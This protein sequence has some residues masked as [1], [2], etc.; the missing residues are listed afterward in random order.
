MLTVAGIL[1]IAVAIYLLVKQYDNRLVL[2]VAGVALSLLALNPMAPFKAFSDA[3]KESKLFEPIVAV[4]GFSLVMKAT[5]CDKHLITLLARPL[6]RAGPLLIPAAVIV[7]LAVNVSITSCAGA[8]A[9][10]GSILIP[11]LMGAGVHPAIAASAVLAGTYAAMLNPG[12]AQVVIVADVAKVAPMAVVANHAKAVIA[13][14]LIGAASLGVVAWLR[15]EHRGYVPPNAAADQ[16][17]LKVSPLK[18]LVPLLPLAILVLGST[19]TVVA[20]K[21]LGISHAMIIGVFAAFLVTRTS[22]ARLSKEF[23]N[24]AGE[25]FGH[26]FGIITC[27]LVFVGGLTAAGL[28][29]ALIQQMTTHPEIAK[30][31]AAAG[32]FL[33]GLVS[34]SGDAAA[35]AFNKA[36]TVHAASFGV[37][38]VSMGSMASIGG[39]LGRTMSP[40]AGGA[41]ICAG[42]AGVNPLEIPKRN[43]PGMLVALAVTTLLLL[44]V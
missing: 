19:G 27:A 39:A 36:V 43:G 18:A 21:Q 1:V 32:P 35:V 41:V 17:E 3:M 12:Y 14:G 29:A 26:V 6:R 33:L 23:W 13:S 31:S 44:Y 8:S 20:F 2:F 7:T 40:I 4:M 37:S 34:G 15:K 38:P 9:A 25:A 5:G 28:V 42:L 16:A 30:L 11:L 22:P 10:V 24:G